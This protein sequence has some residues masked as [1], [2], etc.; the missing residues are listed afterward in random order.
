MA[1][2]SVF[3][4][5]TRL[6]SDECAKRGRDDLNNLW[7]EYSMSTFRNSDIHNDATF[8]RFIFDNK[9]NAYTGN[10]PSSALIDMDSQLRF[11]AALTN[12]RSKKQMSMR[13]FV[14]VPDLSR[15]ES[16]PVLEHVLQS[17]RPTICGPA[18][19]SMYFEYPMNNGIR[20][21]VIAEGRALNT[22][23]ERSIGE[24]SKDVLKRMRKV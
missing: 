2:Y 4:N 1:S 22:W 13:N 3:E 17:G 21:M 12:D 16:A 5:D 9:V 10:G 6:T 20:D 7:H 11:S 14:A 24:S 19:E 15:G 18:R 23:D 8:E